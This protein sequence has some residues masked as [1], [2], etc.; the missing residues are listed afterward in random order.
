MTTT[1]LKPN[2]AFEP[3][4]V[5]ATLA[6]HAVPG[7]DR[8]DAE[9]G[10][11]TRLLGTGNDRWAVT[12][13]VGSTGVEVETEAPPDRLERMGEVIRFWFDLD[14]DLEPVV[15]QFGDDPLLG[16]MVAARPGLRVTRSPE[17]FEAAIST[18]LG[19][20]V[21]VARGRTLGSRLLE[22]C[23][24]PEL[25][26]LIAFPEPE[27]LAAQPFE[28]LRDA[29]GLTRSRARTV[30]AVAR[31]FAEGFTLETGPDR[32]IETVKSELLEVPGV[33][34]WTADY[35]AVRAIGHPD[36]F[37]AGDAVLRRALDRAPEREVA[38]LAERWS[39]WRSYA[40][41]HLWAETVYGVDGSAP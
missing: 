11:Y 20:Q 33:G 21:S 15:T 37:P 39:P 5:N 34:P 35:L 17:G 14:T 24:G 22:L 31:L 4:P 27:V 38:A 6:A 30:L 26:G 23:G 36:S 3:G 28:K 19:Q 16:P 29:I 40:A 12:V 25:D 2:G 1:F 10:T 32:R 7:A 41:V 18:V 8:F 13:K 9:A